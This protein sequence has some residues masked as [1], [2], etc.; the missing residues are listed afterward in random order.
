MENKKFIKIAGC[1]IGGGMIGFFA[2]HSSVTESDRATADL[3]ALA[4]G[5]FPSLT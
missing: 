4:R 1:A 3:K 5:I 2:S